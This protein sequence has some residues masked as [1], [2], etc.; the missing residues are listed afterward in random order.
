MQTAA[1]CVRRDGDESPIRLP[2]LP[3]I[4]ILGPAV[5]PAVTAPVWEIGRL[6]VDHSQ[7]EAAIRV[8]ESA[9]V[10]PVTGH[11]GK[12]SLTLWF[13]TWLTVVS[14]EAWLRGRSCAVCGERYK[15]MGGCLTWAEKTAWRILW[16]SAGRG[17][18]AGSSAH[19]GRCPC[20]WCC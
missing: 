5:S 3:Y 10:C 15:A 18:E 2:D 13:A 12:C 4:G 19:V 8:I 16:P 20:A 7:K 17:S 1:V 14:V 9:C 11:T 6:L